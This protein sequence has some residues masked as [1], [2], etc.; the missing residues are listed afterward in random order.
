MNSESES[1]KRLNRR[2]LL[3]IGWAAATLAL[4]GQAGVGLYRL[5]KPQIEPGLFGS[6]VN[7]GQVDEFQPGTVT[8]VQKGRFYIS[9]LEDGGILA[10]WQRC[11]HLGCSVPWRS[12]EEIFNC[13]CHSSLFNPVGEV[14]SG[15]SPRPMDLFPV[16]TIDDELLVD[17]GQP[18]Q[19]QAFDPS[20]V[21][22]QG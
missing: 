18:I 12:T 1:K 10:L 13:P 6:V 21:Y 14:I 17:T 7:A 9:R 8:H 19:R 16:N 11:P 15:P 20:Q 3:N 4:V 2:D 22:Y 5:F